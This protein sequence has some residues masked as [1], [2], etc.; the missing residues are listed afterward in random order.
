MSVLDT[1]GILSPEATRLPVLALGSSAAARD[2]S[3]AESGGPY[4]IV[5]VAPSADEA[6]DRSWLAGAAARV[7]REL[8]V[9]G[10]AYVVGP[11]RARRAVRAHLEAAQ[12]VT[13]PTLLH[14]P[15][16]E[17]SANVVPL[18]KA[19]ARYALDSLLGMRRWKRRAA[20][21][22][23]RVSPHLLA[24][25]SPAQ[26]FAARRADAPAP[27][28]WLGDVARATTAVVTAPTGGAGES[29]VLH[30]F[31]DGGD[32]VAVLKL[33]LSPAAT[34]RLRQE[35]DALTRLGPT[36]RDAG[37]RVAHGDELRDPV[38]RPV[39]RQSFVAGRPAA[40]AIAEAPHL[41]PA[42][43]ERVA[44]WLLAWQRA[45]AAARPL[46][47]SE[48]QAMLLD[49]LALVA[50]R[51][52]DAPAYSDWLE[53][54]CGDVEGLPLARVAVHHDLTMANVLLGDGVPIGVVDWEMARED[55]LPLVDLV[56]AIADAAAARERYTARPEAFDEMFGAQPATLAT[57][58]VG[59][60][61]EDLNL[62]PRLIRVCFHA[63]W[64]HH[65][66]N[67]AR[68]SPGGGPFLAILERV[69]RAPSAV[70]R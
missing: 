15:S 10:L 55:G 16:V 22:A 70:A 6:R 62:E 46:A 32:P 24:P 17:I 28:A 59:R 23:V 21:P 9:S 25:V 39:L 52:A 38:D 34:K 68:V 53:A 43:L 19:P 51:L 56:Y 42:V 33:A 65:A 61:T 30:A 5:L 29:V 13:G 1:I 58:L 41:L 4:G 8:D 12:L 67:E 49:P 63:C 2:L 47:R 7:E 36:A 40:R 37:A 31:G 44:D 35:A 69:A 26:G 27:F 20:L 18:E 48:L 57:R 3:A 14:I 11:R 66:A 64:L 54:L 50:P 45:T 60:Q